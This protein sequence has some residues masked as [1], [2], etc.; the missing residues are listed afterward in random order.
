MVAWLFASLLAAVAGSLAQTQINLLALQQ[1]GAPISWAD[2]AATSGE[3]LLGFAPAWL[4]LVAIGFAVALPVSA[5]IARRYGR[6]LFW[7]ALAGGAAV[8]VILLSMN[9][10]LG[11][12]PVAAARTIT[13]LLLMAASGALGGAL[14]GLLT[15]PPRVPTG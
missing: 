14:A 15:R 6:R 11:I 3:D 4:G 7:F 13:G 12:T 5:W 10:L 8:L 1:L 9:A 2:R